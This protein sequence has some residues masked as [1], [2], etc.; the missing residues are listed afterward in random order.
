[1]YIMDGVAYAGTLVDG[2]LI[3]E[4]QVL[5]ELYLL[6]SFSTGEKRVFDASCLLQYPAFAPIA[7]VDVFRSL[8]V[9]HGMLTWQDGK[10]DIAPEAVYARSFA[11]E[12]ASA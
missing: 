7:N 6:V 10:I 12:M 9:E 2:V 3:T 8:Q 5:D 4:V 11:Y 1:M